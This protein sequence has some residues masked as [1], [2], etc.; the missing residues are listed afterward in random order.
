MRCRIAAF[1][2][3]MILAFHLG[4]GTVRAQEEGLLPTI[5]GGA[6]GTETGMTSLGR[7][8]GAG[9]TSIENQPGAGDSLLGSRA[10]PGA[11]RVPSS[12]TT[13]GRASQGPPRRVISAP[14]ALPIADVP[15][16]GPMEIPAG[17][18]EDGPPGGLTLDQ[19]L[20]RLVSE[21]LDL[22]A[23]FHEIPK[24]QADILTAGLRANPL[25]F[26]DA[27][28]VPYGNFSNR[29]EGGPTQF[30]LSINYPLDLNR[31]RRAR[32]DVACRARKVLEAQ[33]Q[34]AVRIEIDN[35]YTA[36]V[37]HLAARETVRY[38]RA[39]ASG[40]AEILG[41]TRALLAQQAVTESD[42]DRIK[43][44]LDAA[45]IGLADA[46]E[47][48]RDTLRALG[49]LL[50]LAPD[51]SE[52]MAVRGTIRDLAPPPPPI[53]ALTA[54]AL[55]ARPDLNAFR[56]GIARAE[57]DV[58]LARAN[59]FQDVYLLFQPY[60][61]YNGAPFGRGSVP[62]WALG[63]TVPLPVNNRNQG[64]I[65][66]AQ[67]NVSQVKTELAARERQAVIDV[68]KAEREY[69]LTRAAVA[70]V[71]REM[72][73]SARR[74]RDTALRRFELGEA[75]AV[76]YLIANREYNDV[77]RQYRDTLVRHRRSMLR[78]NTVV[79]QRLLP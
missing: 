44:Q 76:A 43:G 79:G 53:E 8:P 63:A 57:S 35:L 40:L 58:N 39:G 21:N 1:A 61:G 3:A 68:R 45:E 56:L 62:S 4:G 5:T 32:L 30:D 22:R 60:T 36:F 72:L 13:P 19:A 73:P 27:Q 28:Q 18:E 70:R 31:K 12:I 42:V 37:D 64:N 41:K 33:F 25:L 77:V 66:R 65:Q 47:S 7:T 24:A 54:S 20:D 23:R 29:K 78:L 10:G 34:D 38:S 2:L 67:I 26:F 71:E 74:V 46:E 55:A 69:A 59:R 51:R 11:P 15:L 75:D 48:A 9:G 17:P 52:S 49:G 14:P 50:N 6:A 16:Y